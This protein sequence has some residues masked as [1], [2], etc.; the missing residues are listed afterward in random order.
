MTKILDRGGVFVIMNIE[1]KGEISNMICNKCGMQVGEN[2]LYCTNCGNK[3]ERVNNSNNVFSSDTFNVNNNQ[4][5]ISN[6]NMQSASSN[7]LNGTKNDS[8]TLQE[9]M[10]MQY[11]NQTNNQS[12]SD[13]NI[14]YD[15]NDMANNHQFNGNNQIEA[16]MQF[17]SNSN[18]AD[19]SNVNS[20]NLNNNEKI[21]VDKKDKISLIIGI[22]SVVLSFLLNL[23]VIPLSVVGLIFGIK[24]KIKSKNRIIGIILNI[25]S[26]I[27]AFVIF[28]IGVFILNSSGKTQKYYGS[29]YELEYNRDWTITELSGGQEALEYKYQNSYFI[30]IGKSTL[31]EYTNNLNCDFDESECR[32]SLYN[33][34]YDNWNADM[35]SKNLHLYKDSNLFN[36]L[37]DDIYY[38]KYDYGT[39]ES[40]L[41]G[42]N[43][44]IISKSKDVILS[45]MS[46]AKS[47]K[48]KLL[49]DEIIKLLKNIKIDDQSNS[50]IIEDDE[51]YGLLDSM[52]NWNRYSNLRSGTLGKKLT[53]NG[54]WRKLDDSE[55]YWK[56]KDGKFWW[57]KSVNNL[58]DNYYYGTTK[59]AT[60]LE[61]LKSVGLT[62]E[63]LKNVLSSAN[64]KVSQNDIYA[65]ICTPTKLISDGQDKSSTISE[66]AKLKEVWI[67]INH[68]DEGIEGQTLNLNTYGT[69]YYVKIED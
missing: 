45:F 16:S 2:N 59:I 69:S 14:S 31:T 55:E 68:N 48:L 62:E 54:G 25:S 67:V 24:S 65:I 49:D 34:F 20:N 10:N 56:F 15:A 29:G 18:V 26:I 38:A 17:Q 23:F 4:S 47:K 39:S 9:N 46:N 58:N 52:N 32:E 11:N 12:N 51:T 22:V 30:P 57:Y 1:N 41:T 28:L 3:I 53:I 44:L 50:N 36:H 37:K 61:G 43:Y 7:N 27:I 33:I 35:L 21:I 63:N 42:N 60:G 19:L 13:E 5:T 66:E 8:L 6:G 64:G 40:N